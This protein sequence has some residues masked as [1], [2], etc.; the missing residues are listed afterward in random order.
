MAPI[1]EGYHSHSHQPEVAPHLLQQVIKVPLV[2]SRD[3]DAVRDLVDDVQFLC[4]QQDC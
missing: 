2:V 1:G 4:R 3:G